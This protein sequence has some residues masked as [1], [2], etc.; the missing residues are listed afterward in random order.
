MELSWNMKA[1]MLS[2]FSER[3]RDS[4][5]GEKIR[6]QTIQSI[7]TGWDKMV[8]EQE[9]GGRPINRPRHYEERKRREEKWKK[10]TNWFKTGG[11]TTVL[12]CPWTPNG[13]LARRWREV[14]EK[15]AATRGWRYLAVQRCF[16]G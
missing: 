9:R 5:Y 11:Y 6:Y 8:A 7:L 14:E 10:K 12:F 2:E 4:G 16:C 13:E 1:E 3:M 15:G